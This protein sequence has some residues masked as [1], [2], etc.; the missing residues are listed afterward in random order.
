L[1]LWVFL[2]T[3]LDK[4][5]RP[6]SIKITQQI[7]SLIAE[8][9]EFKGAWKALGQL[10]PDQ[11]ITLRRVATIESTGS[12][13]RIEGSK[14]DDRQ[15]ELLLGNLTITSF[16]TRDEQE[17]A[18]YAEVMKTIFENYQ[19]IDFTE[20]YIKQFNRDL[21]TYSEKDAWHRGEY[22]K[23]KNHVEAFSPEGKSFGIVFETTSPFETPLMMEELVTWTRQAMNERA[24]HPLLMVCIFKIV[25]LAIHP[26]QDGNGRLSRIL[27]NLILLMQGYT[28]TSYSSLE[29]VI[30]NSKE[31]YYLALNKSQRTLKEN[32]PDWQPWIE[33]FL[34][35]LQQQKQKLEAKLE[36]ERLLFIKMPDVSTRI[37]DLVRSR[38]QITIGEIV[39]F[40]NLNRNTIKKH[41]QSLVLDRHLIKH[42]EKKEARYTRY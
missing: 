1:V 3:Y 22:K 32:E 18:G 8:I 29:A 36:K 19:H 25:F 10:A 14:L 31:A 37:L 4:M 23:N 40:T 5:I 41:L 16:N 2:D 21:L 34:K 39:S 26:F 15:V 24:L 17:V 11:L 7:L 35:A 38:G 33:Y 13:T 6:D 12:S 42:G 20:N 30:E 27:T 9:D 28:Y